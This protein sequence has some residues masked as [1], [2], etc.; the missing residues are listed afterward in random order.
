MNLMVY[1]SAWCAWAP[2]VETNE[3]WQAWA[4]GEKALVASAQSPSLT[5][6]EAM[7]KR[8]L[9]QL[10]RMVMHTG[11]VVLQGRQ[12]VPVTLVSRYGEIGQ[13]FKI[14]DKLLAEG[15]VSPAN[16]S[17][18]VF[19]TPVAALSISEGI[20]A[21][22]TVCFP[23]VDEFAQGVLEACAS[24][25]SSSEQNRVLIFADEMIPSEYLPL[26]KEPV[27]PHALAILLQK[28]KGSECL[29]LHPDVFA[30]NTPSALSFI[31]EVLLPS[32]PMS[33]YQETK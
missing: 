15:E 21:G 8:R 29:A 17:L 11:H 6:V 2:E 13:Q 4:R 24:L 20:Q 25:G 31:R 14:T 26:V 27:Q 12:D 7:F 30:V 5:H 1:I 16:F 32:L 33:E 18:S 19:N 22:Y 10:T 23:A 28:E 9:S 3:D